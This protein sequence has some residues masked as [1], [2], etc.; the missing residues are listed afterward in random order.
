M[1]PFLHVLSLSPALPPCSAGSGRTSTLQS[2]SVRS[3]SWLR[4][5][6]TWRRPPVA[7]PPPALESTRQQD[8]P[9]YGATRVR[10]D[11]LDRA[12]RLRTLGR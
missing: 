3:M 11:L 4:A 7:A 6:T 5:F 8:L 10:R 2:R 1:K 12:E 9:R